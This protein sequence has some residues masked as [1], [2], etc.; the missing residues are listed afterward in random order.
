MKI[1]KNGTTTY[2]GVHMTWNG[3]TPMFE[4]YTPSPNGSGGVDGRVVTAGSQRPAEPSSGYAPPYNKVVIVVK[5]SDLGLNAGDTISGFVSGVSQTGGGLITELYDQ[6]PDSLAFTGSYTVNDNQVCRPNN[7]P[8]AVLPA[9]PTSGRPAL[10]AN[11]DGSG[12]YDTD[13][14]PLPDTIASYTFSFGDGSPAVTQSTP[15][16][17]HRY[18]HAGT[19]AARLTVTD[20]RGL[21]SANTATVVIRLPQREIEQSGKGYG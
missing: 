11:F 3:T 7:P 5:G 14:A 16:I 8:T 4:S 20:S 13:T 1:I 21:Q 6:M 9:S 19:Y 17:S 15:T 10:T 12:S 2:K 18:Q